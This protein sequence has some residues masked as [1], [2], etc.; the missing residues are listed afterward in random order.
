ML[1]V[2]RLPVDGPISALVDRVRAGDP[3]ADHAVGSAARA[4]GIALASTVNVLDIPVVVLGGHL[5]EA[6]DVLR[7]RLVPELRT[8]VLSSEWDAPTVEVAAPDPAPGATGGAYLILDALVDN[9]AA[10]VDRAGI[11]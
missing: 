5:A 11:G 9:P 6:A 1:L 4:L 7:P 8:R 2:A 3:L 10:W